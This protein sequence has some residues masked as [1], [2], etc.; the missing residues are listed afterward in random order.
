MEILVWIGTGLTAL[1]FCG[2]VWTIFAVSRARRAGLDDAGLRARL[3]Q[4][5]PWNLGALALSFLGLMMVVVGV[6]L[7]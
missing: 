5:L 4:I 6:I 7:G 3:G 1:G 2:I